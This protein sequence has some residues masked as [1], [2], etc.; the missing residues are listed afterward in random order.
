MIRRLG[1]RAALALLAA[2]P[3][4]LG[5]RGLL[6]RERPEQKRYVLEVERDEAQPAPGG[7][8]SLAVRPYTASSHL[9]GTRFVYRVGP[10]VQ[11]FDYYH[12]FW[13][14]PERM[15]TDATIRW[16]AGSGLFALVSDAGWERP[17][18]LVLDGELSELYGDYRDPRAPRAVLKLRC[19]LLD[20]SG[21]A[22][23]VLLSREYFSSRP[24]AP[25]SREA[26]V[27]GWNEALREVLAAL[28]QD[29]AAAQRSGSRT[30]AIANRRPGRRS[31]SVGGQ[32]GERC[33]RWRSGSRCSSGSA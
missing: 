27:A 17:G 4:G 31:A 28:E 11:D 14:E 19:T 25:A 16:L 22:S 15:V 32:K 12:Q 2:L 6:V 29:L 13:A 21:G 10:D 23:R 24:V 26:L 18:G 5:C 1:R 20:E 7:A 30:R 3:L 8:P 9:Y 33:S